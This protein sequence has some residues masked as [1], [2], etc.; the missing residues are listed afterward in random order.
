MIDVDLIEIVLSGAVTLLT[1]LGVRWVTRIEQRI[2]RV[3][4]EQMALVK[5]S[6]TKA[7]VEAIG[8]RL[9]D[10]LGRVEERLHNDVMALT[11]L[12]RKSDR[13]RSHGPT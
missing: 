9:E 4:G 11:A 10:R 13:G 12:H 2:D 5:A 6:A 3:E 1:L 7:D 8:R